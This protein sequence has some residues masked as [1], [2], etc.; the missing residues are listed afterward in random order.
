[1]VNAHTVLAAAG[2]KIGDSPIK[3]DMKLGPRTNLGAESQSWG[4]I[5]LVPKS[6]KMAIIIPRRRGG[7]S[8]GVP[9]ATWSSE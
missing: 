9:V 6:W 3:L 1:M 8:E 7:T 2:E 5:E 4:T